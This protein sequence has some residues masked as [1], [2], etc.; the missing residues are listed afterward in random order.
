[1]ALLEEFAAKVVRAMLGCANI[2][3]TGESAFES[4]KGGRCALIIGSQ[5]VYGLQGRREDRAC[6]RFRSDS[7]IDAQVSPRQSECLTQSPCLAATHD[8]HLC[9]DDQTFATRRCF[10]DVAR[11]RNT[12]SYRGFRSLP[13]CRDY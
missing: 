11:E 3:R 12:L 6:S 13:R 10:V 1:M 5:S 2:E 7:S 8:L 9:S 4:W